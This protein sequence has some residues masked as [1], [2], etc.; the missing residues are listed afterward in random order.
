MTTTTQD[1]TLEAGQTQASS[2]RGV[3]KVQ[4][5]PIAAYV[6]VSRKGERED[7]R[8]RSPEFQLDA[9]ERA[10]DAAGRRLQ[11]FEPEIDV[12]GSRARRPILEAIVEAI[13]RGELGGVMV[14]KLD[15]LSRLRPIDRITLFERIEGAGGVILSA[16]ENLDVST[17]EGRFARDVFLGVARLE[18]E[19]KAEGFATA[20]RAAVERGAKIASVAPFGYRFGEGHRLEPVAGDRDVVVELFEAR[21]AGASRGEL[22]E[23]FETRT[24]RSSHRS[25][26]ATMLRNRSYLGEVHYGRSSEQ[27]ANLDAHEAIVDVDL[28][29]AVQAVDA[30]RSTGTGSGGK[31]KSLLAGVARCANCGRGLISSRTGSQRRRAYKCAN[32]A[33]HCSARAHIDAELLDAFVV[34]GVLEWAGPAADQL[35]ELELELGAQTP[36]IVLEH[37]LAEARRVLVEYEADVE[38]ELEVGAE[39]YAAGRRA[40]VELVAKREAELAAAGAESAVELARTTL[41]AEL[42]G[43]ELSLIERRRLLAIALDEVVVRRTPRRGAPAVERAELRFAAPAFGATRDDATELLEELVADAAAEVA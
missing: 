8:F 10:A 17:P 14:A 35:V 28:F 30:A 6:R 18:W 32:D 29:E 3:R 15:R 20:K 40:R 12:S 5:K 25:T 24:G 33:K 7:D 36:R 4:A 41:R 19:R 42:A 26:I 39:A 16:S 27:L 11:R 22:L 2:T 43:D 23:L 1:H 21:A 34:E 9:I 31:P 13:E 38:R 37:Q